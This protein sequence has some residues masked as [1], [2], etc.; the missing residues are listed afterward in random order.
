MK[1]AIRKSIGALL[2]I[3]ALIVTQIPPLG[4]N[5]NVQSP[6]FLMDHSTLAEYT[7]TSTNVSVPD[8]VITIGEEAF[9]G[10]QYIGVVHTGINTKHIN[11]GAFA[12]CSYLMGV[13]LGSKVE[14]IDAAAFS[15]CIN[16]QSVSI[17]GDVEK[18][19]TGIFAGCQNLT[20]VS[21]DSNN[22][23]L[24]SENQVLYNYD[25]SKILAY[26][27]GNTRNIYVMPNSVEHIEPYS[28]WGNTHLEDV[29]LSGSLDEISGYS[30]ANCSSLRTLTI[31]YS[32]RSIDAKA[33]EN[34]V[35]LGNVVIPAS[36]SYIDPTAFDG[37]VN[38]NIIADAGTVAY[39]FFRNFDR[40]DITNTEKQ[41]TKVIVE[42]VSEP[43]AGNNLYVD[44]SKDPRNVEWMPS[45]DSLSSGND[46]SILGKTIIVSGDALLFINKDMQVRELTKDSIQ[47]NPVSIENSDDSVVYDSGKGGYLPKY[48]EANGHVA[49]QA[50]YGADNMDGYT[51]PD[52]INTIGRFAFARSNISTVVIPEGVTHIGY[53][54]F[55]HCDDLS[56]VS[57][58]SSVKTIDEYA[59]ENTPFISNV[60]SLAD[61]NGYIIVGDGVLLAYT[62]VGGDI[63][64]PGNV[65]HISGG[66]FKDNSSITGVSMPDSV[67]DIG[68]DAFRGCASL[69]RVNLGNGVKHIG[70]RAFMG[71]P[72]NGFRIPASVETIG[73]RAIDYAQTNKTDESRVVIF[74]GTLPT[75]TADETSRRLSNAQYRA[76]V[77]HNVLFAVVDS[78]I[79]DFANTV[80]DDEKL[81]FSGMILK[82]N[83]DNTASIVK[84]YIYSEEVMRNLP[85]SIEI[86]GENYS[87]TGISDAS[88][89]TLNR[90]SVGHS[91][92]I[93]CLYNGS[94]DERVSAKFTVSSDAGVLTINESIEAK[95]SLGQAYAKLFGGEMPDII[96][97]DVKLMDIT[98]TCN[99]DKFGNSMLSVTIPVDVENEDT[100]HVITLDEDGQ[101]EELNATVNSNMNAITF[102]TNHLSYIGVYRNGNGV[103]SL[104]DGKLIQ[105]HRLDSSPDT[106]DHSIPVNYILAIGLFAAGVILILLKDNKHKNN[107][108][109][110]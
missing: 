109:V 76:D 14:D 93:K 51:I 19:G 98:N 22:K 77:L 85:Q 108:K 92:S 6:V 30:F 69:E 48:T 86:N 100:I 1:K 83:S 88:T 40:S 44:A 18:V 27:G 110:A 61:G 54:A 32:V 25:Q 5:A 11:H 42:E 37:C 84:N 72:V 39:E 41:D 70:D 101:L 45:V 33:F 97:Y 24:K 68:S 80:L 63:V 43:S 62:G 104:K 17:G 9:A 29:T 81:G 58:P 2:I 67:E 106:G 7:G 60:A 105:N 16:L 4:T 79:N 34:C 74:E 94:E 49:M 73:L 75:I 102:A 28:F 35:S 103:L 47:D 36:V 65:K 13:T 66:C 46:S 78:S 53:G 71:C 90:N 8:D 96:G 91:N 99:I 95:N 87:I 21:V 89:G 107:K 31:P 20:K 55:Y 57:F 26:L 38:L 64:I 15:G 10:N 23:Y 3:T 82:L 12:N 56:S 50:Y 59:F 52:G